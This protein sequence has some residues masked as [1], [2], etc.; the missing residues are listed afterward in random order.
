MVLQFFPLSV[1]IPTLLHINRQ[2]FSINAMSSRHGK[3]RSTNHRPQSSYLIHRRQ[4]HSPALLC[5]SFHYFSHSPFSATQILTASK[6]SSSV[7]LFWRCIRFEYSCPLVRPTR[8]TASENLREGEELCPSGGARLLLHLL[9]KARLSVRPAAWE[10]DGVEGGR[11]HYGQWS[12]DTA[13]LI[14]CVD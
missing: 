14:L 3:R 6:R 7:A 9:D 8:T 2:S 10:R 1:I 12:S 13:D 4:S 11:A 5:T